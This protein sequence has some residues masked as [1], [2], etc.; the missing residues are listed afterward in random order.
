MSP[1]QPQM[2]LWAGLVF[3]SVFLGGMGL[4][5]AW[6]DLQRK[7]VQRRLQQINSERDGGRR[8]PGHHP[9][10]QAERHAVRR[11]AAADSSVG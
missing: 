3:A 6:M 2:F 10:S 1:M 11:Q 8:G 4:R 9:R 7:R 5:F